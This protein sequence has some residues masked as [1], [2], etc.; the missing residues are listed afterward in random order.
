MTKRPA[1]RNFCCVANEK[2]CQKLLVG[3]GFTVGVDKVPMHNEYKEVFECN[4]DHDKNIIKL[5]EL[6][7]LANED[8]I[9]SI[10]TDSSAVKVAFGLVF[11]AKSLV[12]HKEKSGK[13]QADKQLSITYCHV[14]DDIEK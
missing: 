14:P 9:L 13:G 2:G 12:Y 4:T 11:S 10:N 8:L 6:I 7:D 5:G 1:W 3:D